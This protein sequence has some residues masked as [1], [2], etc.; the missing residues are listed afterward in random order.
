MGKR[1]IMKFSR[2][3]MNGMDYLVIR[4]QKIR[5]KEK[6]A[7]QNE[8]LLA[9]LNRPLEEV[10]QP[11]ED[12]KGLSNGVLGFYAILET[13]SLKDISKRALDPPGSYHTYLCELS[14]GSVKIQV[15]EY[16]HWDF[17]LTPSCRVLLIPPIQVHR[18]LYLV[19]P[20]NILLLTA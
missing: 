13:I 6:F 8:A 15:L 11:N 16:N 9:I 10:I 18:G 5:L 17:I 20:N 7:S 14:D 2:I 3:I 1:N 19:N 4:G 12:L